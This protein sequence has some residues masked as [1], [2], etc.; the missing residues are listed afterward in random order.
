[1]QRESTTMVLLLLNVL[2]QG[3]EFDE[4]AATLEEQYG[5]P[6][7]QPG[8]WAA[9]VRIVDPT[10]LSTVFVT[11]LDNNEGITAMVLAELTSSVSGASETVLALGT[12]QGLKYKPTDCDGECPTAVYSCN[13]RT[14]GRQ[15]SA[16]C[17]ARKPAGDR[18]T[19]VHF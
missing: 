13:N 4:E 12:A 1:M 11:E 2:P 18:L 10:N 15:P 7:G 8:Q 19:F 14:T 17:A 5:A 6:C 9:C 16:T 3:V